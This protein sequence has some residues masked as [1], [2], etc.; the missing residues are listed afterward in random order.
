LGLPHHRLRGLISAFCGKSLISTGHFFA[1]ILPL[2][3][4]DHKAG[5]FVVPNYIS[6]KEQ[7]TRDG[8][9]TCTISFPARTSG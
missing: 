7:R 9:N 6:N 3:Y 4:R 5:L 8:K 1:P 2:Y